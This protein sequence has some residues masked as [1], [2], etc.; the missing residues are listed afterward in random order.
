MLETYKGILPPKGKTRLPMAVTVNNQMP[1]GK[2]TGSSAA[3]R[4]AGIALAVHFGDLGWSAK[5]LMEEA[6]RR[7]GH[8]D[9][10]A[11]CWLGGFAVSQGQRLP[12]SNTQTGWHPT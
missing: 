5:R 8:A 7:E 11:A 3:A 1:I 6:A 2:G 4:L 12:P 10:V 9:N